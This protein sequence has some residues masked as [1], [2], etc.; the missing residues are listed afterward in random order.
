MAYL[1]VPLRGRY[2]NSDEPEVPCID[3]AALEVAANEQHKGHGLRFL[4]D[5]EALATKERL[6]LFIE[7]VNVPWIRKALKIRGY[8]PSETD[9]HNFHK[10]FF[11]HKTPNVV[12]CLECKD[13]APECGKSRECASCGKELPICCPDRACSTYQPPRKKM[14]KDK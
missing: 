12:S 11:A 14:R 6:V 8:T 5:I 3:L 13:A 9:P 10:D 4:E 2:L 1:R 7:A